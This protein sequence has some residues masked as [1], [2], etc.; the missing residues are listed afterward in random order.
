MVPA[1]YLDGQW[2][3]LALIELALPSAS[4][5]RKAAVARVIMAAGSALFVVSVLVSLWAAFRPV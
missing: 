3:T 1:Y 4:G 2:A 5:A